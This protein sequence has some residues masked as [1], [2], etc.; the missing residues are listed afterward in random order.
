[1]PGPSDTPTPTGGARQE[2]TERPEERSW[3]RRLF[4]G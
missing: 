1:M 3:W 2:A 4:E